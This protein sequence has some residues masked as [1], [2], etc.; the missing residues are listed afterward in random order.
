[1]GVLG[2]VSL[3]TYVFVYAFGM[4]SVLG[5][6]EARAT[7]PGLI[8]QLEAG[9]SDGFVIGSHRKAQAALVSLDRFASTAPASQDTHAPMLGRVRELA[10]IIKRLARESHI[11]SVSVFGSVAR[12]DDGPESDIDLLAEMDS[13]GS[14]FHLAHFQSDMEVLFERAID[15]LPRDALDPLK[16]DE[17]LSEAIQL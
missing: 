3:N 7:L 11:T 9:A 14:Y 8:E 5:I 4:E 16:N 2:R 10:G 6:V 17:I 1:M 15:V 12:G 13:E